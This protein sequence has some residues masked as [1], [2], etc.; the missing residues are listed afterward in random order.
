M[1]PQD[2]RALEQELAQH[3]TQEKTEL[4]FTTSLFRCFFERARYH[5]NL[6]TSEELVMLVI[7]RRLRSWFLLSDTSA[8]WRCQRETR[9]SGAWLKDGLSVH[10]SPLFIQSLLQNVEYSSFVT[11]EFSTNL[12]AYNYV[13]FCQDVHKRI[14]I[15]IWIEPQFWCNYCVNP[16]IGSFLYLPKGSLCNAIKG[17]H[18]N[19]CVCF[20]LML[21]LEKRKSANKPN[22]RKGSKERKTSMLGLRVRLEKAVSFCQTVLFTLPTWLELLMF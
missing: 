10:L 8:G 2:V 5:A 9:S 20:D 22:L 21:I 13:N 1:W 19:K 14:Q 11:L 3:I 6:G 18:K 15:L 12:S 7:Q 17:Y 4:H 16:N